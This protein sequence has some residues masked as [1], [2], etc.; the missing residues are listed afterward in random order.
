M[1]D[2]GWRS[3][4][5]PVLVKPGGCASRG[6]ACAES[7][8]ARARN[9]HAASNALQSKAN[10][11]R[12]DN[13]RQTEHGPRVGNV[14]EHPVPQ[15]D[16]CNDLQIVKRREPRRRRELDRLEYREIAC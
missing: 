1:Q 6:P 13:D 9:G 7:A 10:E 11:T 5:R 8:W 2:R 16:G 4:G 14:T 15:C 3:R 12:R